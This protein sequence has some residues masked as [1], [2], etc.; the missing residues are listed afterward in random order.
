MT[1]PS[2]ASRPAWTCPFCPLLCDGFDVA[3]Q[4]A[5]GLQ[6]AGSDC[7]RAQAALAR[8]APAGSAAPQ[9]AGQPVA[10]DMAIAEAARRLAAS[11]QPLFGGL[12]TDVAGA[13]ALYALACACGAICDAA[14]GRPLM[15]STRALQDRGGFATSLA[16]VRSRADLVLCLGGPPMARYPEFAAR[17]GL[18]ADDP[19]WL[20]L[21]AGQSADDWFAPVAHLAALVE[22]RA[23]AGAA[24]ALQAAAQRLQAA[25]YAVVVV[26]TA[27]LGE[28]GALLIEML[29]RVVATLNRSTR[30]AMLSLGGADG[31]STVNGV[32]TWLSGLP[33]RTRLG[34]Q[35]LEHDPVAFD[36]TTL[37]ADGAVD[38]LLWLA[39]FGT[40][41]PPPAGPQPRI[42]IGH[43]SLAALP[44]DVFIPVATPGIGHDGHLFRTDGV[45]MMPLHAVQPTTLPRADAVLRA[46]LSVL[47]GTP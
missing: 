3:P 21:G 34:P 43:P 25:R 38:L 27:A 15:Q 29:Q 2:P 30:A 26:E 33:L 19:R 10:L 35:G 7:A 37:L 41:P 16:E 24:P 1:V 40:E 45:V 18:A 44:A 6:L 17:T 23:V 31:A 12:G 39:S 11:R 9:I 47:K 22:G 14:A 4:P 42:V 32:F 8:F 28:H 36:A 46:L 5:G 20:V 13:R